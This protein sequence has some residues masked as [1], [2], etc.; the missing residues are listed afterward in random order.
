M[1]PLSNLALRPLELLINRGIR[2]SSTAQALAT[3]LEGKSLA[4][5]VEGFPWPVY[6]A[7]SDGLVRVSG[8]GGAQPP[9]AALEGGPLSILALARGDAQA[10]IRDNQLRITG[11]TDVASQFRELLH[12]AAPDFEEELSKVIGD[13]LAHQVGGFVKALA[14]WGGRAA[15]SVS[16][17][18]AEFVTEERQVL[19]TRIEADEFYAQ[20]D[21]LSSDVDR[22]EA[23]LAHL[24][25]AA[26]PT[27]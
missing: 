25:K 27:R 24:R 22:A 12:M 19:P 3:A 6:L 15:Q 26:D 5:R 7:A 18:A 4:L 17:S 9:S 8:D 13:P 10:R 23:R 1:E 21:T 16:R 20:V 2:Q 11:D 14:Q